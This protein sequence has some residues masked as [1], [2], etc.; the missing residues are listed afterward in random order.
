MTGNL[1][2][3]DKSHV[4]KNDQPTNIINIEELDS[5]DI[6]ISRRLAPGIAKRLKNKKG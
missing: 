4:E 3:K 2:D 5:V 1:D 6:P